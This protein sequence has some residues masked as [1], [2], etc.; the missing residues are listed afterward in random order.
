[1]PNESIYLFPAHSKEDKARRE[2]EENTRTV[3]R[4]VRAQQ[5]KQAELAA[6]DKRRDELKAE[7][8][9]IGRSI[10]NMK[11]RNEKLNQFLALAEE[12]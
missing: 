2:R 10:R 6:L 5:E 3:E 7:T 4:W 9:C 11:D 8:G 1:M 12:I